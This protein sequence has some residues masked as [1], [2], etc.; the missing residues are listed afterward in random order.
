M[1]G[2]S[3]HPVFVLDDAFRVIESNQAAAE[4]I[5]VPL[6]QV[7]GMHARDFCHPDELPDTETRMRNLRLGQKVRFERWFRCNGRRRSVRG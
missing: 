4:L 6:D 2:T 3:P 5:G 7:R 1:A